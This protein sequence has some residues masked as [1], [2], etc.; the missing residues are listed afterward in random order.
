MNEAVEKINSILISFNN[1]F[2]LKIEESQDDE[3]NS[4]SIVETI[5]DGKDFIN[6]LTDLFDQV[7]KSIDDKHELVYNEEKGLVLAEKIASID[8]KI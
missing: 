8:Y 1:T 3:V 7:I 2:K 6:E 5:G 4:L